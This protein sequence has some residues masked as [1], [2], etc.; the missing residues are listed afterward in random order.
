MDSAVV[1]FPANKKP[2]KKKILEI[3]QIEF[4]IQPYKV[5]GSGLV[6][7]WSHNNLIK[8]SADSSYPWRTMPATYAPYLTRAIFQLELLKH[9]VINGKGEQDFVISLKQHLVHLDATLDQIWEEARQAALKDE[10]KGDWRSPT[11]DRWLA[12]EYHIQRHNPFDIT[13]FEEEDPEH[14]GKLTTDPFD[15]GEYLSHF[16]F[17][18]SFLIYSC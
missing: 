5:P 14:P 15:L 18:S 4:T 2:S 1:P 10:M 13:N 17:L 11:L 16:P 7:I 9:A 12:I 3:V 6:K 8:N